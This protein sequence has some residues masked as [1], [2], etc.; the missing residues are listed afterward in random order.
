MDVTNSE[1]PADN[2]V[3]EAKEL[4]RVAIFLSNRV[5]SAGLNP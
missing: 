4:D 5:G 1:T 3:C 2:P